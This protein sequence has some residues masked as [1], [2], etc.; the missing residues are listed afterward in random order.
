MNS[1]EIESKKYTLKQILT[2]GRQR[3]VFLLLIARR[4]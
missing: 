2:E 4:I 1:G 3:K